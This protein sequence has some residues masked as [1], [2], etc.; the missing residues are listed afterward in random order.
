MDGG[1]VPTS[2]ETREDADAASKWKQY[3]GDRDQVRGGETGELHRHPVRD[4]SHDDNGE[5][6]AAGR[7]RAKDAGDSAEYEWMGGSDEAGGWW[8]SAI[9]GF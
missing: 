6:A 2:R 8:P 9:D 4:V 1:S 5:C 7:A 3:G